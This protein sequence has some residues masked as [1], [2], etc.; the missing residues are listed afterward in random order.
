V[1]KA[2]AY[3]FID[4]MLDQMK[5]LV[6]IQGLGFALNC[7]TKCYLLESHLMIKRAV[8]LTPFFVSEASTWSET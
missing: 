2:P 6:H 8:S 5:V 1:E 3:T 7:F 4:P